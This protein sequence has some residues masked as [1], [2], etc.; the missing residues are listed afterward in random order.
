MIRPAR[1]AAVLI[2]ICAC[3]VGA[4]AALANGGGGW[5]HGGHVQRPDFAYNI[6]PPGQYGGAG[7]TANSTDQ[8]PLYDSL[9]PLRGHV[10]E[11]D[12][13]SHFKREDF[14]PNGATTVVPTPGH[15]D[16]NIVRDSFGV[17]HIYAKTRSDLMYGTG[18]VTGQD[19]WLLLLLG[20]G[21]ARAAVAEVPGVDAFSLVTS[22]RTFVPSAQSE[23][24]VTSEQ[25]KLVDTYGNKGRQILADLKDY[26]AGVTDGIPES[27][28]PWTVND[29]IAVTAFIG[30]IFGNGGGGEVRNAEFLAKLRTQ[31]GVK[32]GSDA[33]VD[34]MEADDDDA[35]TTTNRRFNYG[36]SGGSPTEGSPLVDPGSSQTLSAAPNRLASNFLIV[37]PFRSST[38]ESLAVMGPQLGY[39]YP[40]IV[41]EADLHG[42][43]IQ[44]QGALVPG[45]S[46]YVLIGRTKDYA[47]SL[48]TASS[49]NRDQFLEK[50][51]EPDGSAPTRD[52]R[53]YVY[54]GQ[55]RAM[56]TFDAGTLDGVPQVYPITVHGPVFGTVTV[57][58][59]PYAIARQRSTYGEDGNSL[60]ALHDMTTGRGRTVNGF[61]DSANEF[62]FTFNWGYANRD[63]TAY[64][65]SGKLPRRAPHTNKLLP[66]LGTGNFDW[67]GFISR[68]EHPHDVGGPDGIFLN[69]NNKPA[70]G[71]QTGD[72]GHTYGSVHRVQMFDDF[73]R[74]PAI[75]DVASVMNRA[76]TEDLRATELWPVIRRVLAGSPAPDA[77]TAQAADI[78]TKWSNAGGSKLDGDLDGNIDDPGAAIIGPAWTNIANA[79]LSPALGPL[80]TDLAGLQG[81]NS[82]SFGGGWYGY[83]DKDLRTLLGQRLRDPFH[84]HYCGNG[85]LSACRASLWAAL[86]AA[87]DPLAAAQGPDPTKWRQDATA[88]RIKFAPGLLSQTMRFTNRSTFQQILRFGR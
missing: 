35:P 11:D 3:L 29:A 38:R 70:P 14:A 74:H 10:T 16:L 41:L 66:T 76:A 51:C 8:L 34:L 4:P 55:C 32:R 42:P 64:F 54:R 13:K 17:P 71:W 81:I 80:T 18:L 22:L 61:F 52:S 83:V 46:P 59:K 25:Q 48:T 36:V 58:G 68:D 5:G 60:A 86:K 43:G 82:G 73:P 30:S 50:L 85:S 12:I 62:G 28:R 39:Y 44:A 24:L 6:L 77:L 15:P 69:W 56:T 23:A 33:F 27:M 57:G 65:S 53:H 75:A 2:A 40:E 7:L 21:P 78:L 19:R 67:R 88:E 31:L 49:D 84:L 63:T 72:D 26:A 9:T 45:G 47:W 79:V 87:V 37:N 1:P 20:R